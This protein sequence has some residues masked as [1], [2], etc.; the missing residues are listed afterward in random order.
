MVYIQD[1]FQDTPY[2]DKDIQQKISN[3]GGKNL[4]SDL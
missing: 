4:V 1:E 2:Q 3:Q